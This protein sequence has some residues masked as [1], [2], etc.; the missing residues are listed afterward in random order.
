MKETVQ[1]H[2]KNNTKH[3]IYKYTYYQN[4]H[5]VVKTPHTYSPTHYKT[6]PNNYSTRYTTNEIVIIQWC[7]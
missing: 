7:C 2:G 6:S 4:T 5:T 1:E 3:S